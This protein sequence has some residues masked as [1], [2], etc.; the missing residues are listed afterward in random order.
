MF[1][2]DLDVE[3]FGPFADKPFKV[4]PHITVILGPNE[5]GKSAIRAFIRMVLFGFVKKNSPK[6]NF[7]NYPPVIG[8]LESGSISI[9]TVSSKSYSVH[10]KRKSQAS[11]N[12]PVTITGDES[13]DEQLLGRLIGNIS[14]DVYQNIFSIS[15]EEL[16]KLETS[17]GG[18]ISDRIYSA[19]LGLGSIS[20]PEVISKLDT[21]SR[22]L[23][24][25]S[26]AGSIRVAM[27][28][29]GQKTTLL[30]TARTN[31]Q[32]YEALKREEGEIDSNITA[33]RDEKPKLQI[34]HK[35]KER[36][37][38]LRDPWDQDNLYEQQIKELLS[39]E[40]FPPNGLEKYAEATQK[41]E[42]LEH[43]I[44]EGNR[45]AESREQSI[46]QLDIA[47]G[48]EQN[49]PD[50]RRLITEIAHYQ[51]ASEDLPKLQKDMDDG[52]TQIRTSLSELKSHLD[53]AQ[54]EVEN[55]G[56]DGDNLVRHF[57]L[58]QDGDIGSIEKDAL[59]VISQQLQRLQAKSREK[60]NLEHQIWNYSTQLA[61]IREVKTVIPWWASAAAI[62]TGFI[63]I[64]I[65]AMLVESS[66]VA[67]GI[68][69]IIIGSGMFYKTQYANTRSSATT[70]GV[71]SMEVLVDSLAQLIRNQE[72]LNGEILKLL[73]IMKLQELPSDGDLIVKA[74]A[75]QALINK[76]GE[77]RSQLPNL[78]QFRKRVTDVK[79]TLTDIE[80]RLS[81]ILEEAGIAQFRKYFA[82]SA[83][84]ILEQRFKSHEDSINQLDAFQAETAE[85]NNQLTDYRHALEEVK[86]EL[87]SL[88]SAAK[89]D[90]ESA[91]Q[92]LSVQ[93]KT[94]Q[95]FIADRNALHQKHPHLVNQDGEDLRAELRTISG[96]QAAVELENL[97]IL[98]AD[99]ERELEAQLVK[100]TT[101]KDERERTEEL[102]LANDIRFDLG[103][104]QEKLEDD[105]QRWAVL[106]IA[107]KLLENA[108]DEF[109][110]ERQEP[111]VQVA[112][113]QF[114]R[115]TSGKYS[116][117]QVVIGEEKMQVVEP[118][119]RTKDATALSRGTAEQLYLAMRFALIDEYSRN[120]ESMPVLLDDVMV[121]FDPDRARS[122]CDGIIDIARRHQVLVLT[123]H[124]TTVGQLQAAA[125]DAGA[126]EISVIE[127]E[128]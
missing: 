112:S 30:N 100:H 68:F 5:A 105:A 109:Q 67:A 102:N 20:L 90:D 55:L 101:I 8:G 29:I 98:I 69:I 14:E 19:G 75:I 65:G 12:G 38:A 44:Q 91:F 11:P 59:D 23:W 46:I 36:L 51:K 87:T 71:D 89:C 81:P 128:P 83:L 96:D 84:Q 17:T 116:Q 124:P 1:I 108:K 63:A 4:S 76:L 61:S 122:V 117:V 40:V 3:N 2:T 125:V 111:L 95:K 28:D 56:I 21:E 22:A 121:N 26:S 74:Q 62:L 78:N 25:K 60:Q 16:A 58:S 106:A 92:L 107:R 126:P 66:G 52:E 73:A 35:E 80:S 9:Q 88:L 64:L 6:Y 82:S 27:K 32:R 49:E 18:E 48:F 24:G 10:R 13:G 115:F 94:Q 79:A 104:L 97:E 86:M 37:V 85:W 77:M 53:M 57:E 113:Q 34:K 103:G 123:C 114:D 70:K 110:Q 54:A 118:S 72:I 42:D 50:I 99:K 31:F 127:I 45:K 7:Y 119:K 33:I 43:K 39:S 41:K 120:S 47:N 93:A 15:L